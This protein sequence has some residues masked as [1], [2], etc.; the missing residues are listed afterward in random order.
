MHIQ[1]AANT[2]VGGGSEN[3]A[4]NTPAPAVIDTGIITS[5]RDSVTIT[6]NAITKL[7]VSV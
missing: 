1:V 7:T 5:A 4:S 6:A 3:V 2:G